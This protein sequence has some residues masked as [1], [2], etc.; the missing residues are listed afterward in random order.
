MDAT[1]AA[2]NQSVYRDVNERIRNLGHSISHAKFVCECAHPEC[3]ETIDMSLDEYEAIRCIP[4]HF[5]VI[6]G[7]EHFFPDVE[8]IFETHP[9]YWV[10]E[11]FGQSGVEA[12]RQDPRRVG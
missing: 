10:V 8:R 12:I 7:H 1:K 3:N 5:L 4:H 6:A 2:Q 11:K 9:G